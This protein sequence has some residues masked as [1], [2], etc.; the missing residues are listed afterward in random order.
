MI[1]KKYINSNSYQFK[2]KSYYNFDKLKNSKIASY[3]TKT[4][5]MLDKYKDKMIQ[6]V[7]RFRKSLHEQFGLFAKVH[8][9]FPKGRNHILLIALHTAPNQSCS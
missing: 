2:K 1:N 5:Y 4:R 9:G 6:I 7:Y 3:F 8:L